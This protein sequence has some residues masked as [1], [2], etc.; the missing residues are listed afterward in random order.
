MYRGGYSNGDYSYGNQ[1][2]GNSFNSR[3][4]R[5]GSYNSSGGKDQQS[6]YCLPSMRSSE[7]AMAAG[8]PVALKTE[9]FSRCVLVV[10]PTS[11]AP[12][13]FTLREELVE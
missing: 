7:A 9:K 12:C 1:G 2:S 11:L 6:R 3:P 13:I 5:Q 4:T 8:M 10:S